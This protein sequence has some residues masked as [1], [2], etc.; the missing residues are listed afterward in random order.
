MEMILIPLGTF[1]VIITLLIVIRQAI[2]KPAA[3]RFAVVISLLAI[4][5]I[6]LVSV[7]GYAGWNRYSR[8]ECAQDYPNDPILA[9]YYCAG[10]PKLS[11]A[12][13]PW[14]FRIA[15]IGVLVSLSSLI[16]PEILRW[17]KLKLSLGPLRDVFFYYWELPFGV[18]AI[19]IVLAFEYLWRESPVAYRLLVSILIVLPPFLLFSHLSEPRQISRRV[20]R[21][22]LSYCVSWIVLIGFVFFAAL[23]AG[24]LV[25][26]GRP[27]D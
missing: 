10:S 21:F 20:L 18:A 9:D 13:V 24:A 27:I 17:T 1:C 23:G 15:V 25:C 2:G 19:L 3:R 11:T 4:L 22:V 8:A 5:M 26:F 7:V 16:L 12:R 6:L 14:T